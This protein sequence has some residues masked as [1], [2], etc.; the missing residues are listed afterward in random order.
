MVIRNLLKC[1]FAA[2][3]KGKT[4]VKFAKFSITEGSIVQSDAYRSYRKPLAEKYLHEY[5]IFDADSDMLHW[6]HIIIG[7]PKRLCSARFM[8]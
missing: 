4:L 8:V 2:N 3:L 6:L 5:Q 7:K 1:R